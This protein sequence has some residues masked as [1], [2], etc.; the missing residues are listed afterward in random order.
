MANKTEN[1]Q[2]FS[3]VAISHYTVCSQIQVYY[4]D[5]ENNLQLNYDIQTT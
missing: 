2:M 5:M 4:K 1:S 3:V